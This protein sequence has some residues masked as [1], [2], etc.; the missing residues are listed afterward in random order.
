[1]KV[2]DETGE[3]SSGRLTTATV[4]MGISWKTK[5]QRTPD[6]KSE[7]A[8]VPVGRKPNDRQDNTTCLE[9]RASASIMSSG[10][11][12]EGACRKANHT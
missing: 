4:T 5:S 1:M 12:S 9:G 6:E 2:G 7:E 11:V 10:E 8:I 3:V